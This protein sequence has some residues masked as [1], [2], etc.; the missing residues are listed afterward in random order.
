MESAGGTGLWGD[1]GLRSPSPSSSDEPALD[2]SMQLLEGGD[3]SAGPKDHPRPPPTPA[4]SLAHWPEIK[5]APGGME[6]A[7]PWAAL[8]GS[9]GRLAGAV[10]PDRWLLPQGALLLGLCAPGNAP[11]L[12][13]EAPP[14]PPDPTPSGDGSCLGA[15]SEEGPA[16][17]CPSPGLLSCPPSP[18][19]ASR[20]N[21]RPAGA[22]RLGSLQDGQQG[23]WGG[24]SALPGDAPSG[25]GGV[26]RVCCLPCAQGGRAPPH[27]PGLERPLHSPLPAAAHV[28]A[29]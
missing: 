29:Q 23:W 19:P 14:P 12:G 18:G 28:R 17:S 21:T 25:V 8:P 27:S 6:A 1:G 4:R 2:T 3:W 15:Q 22:T 16:P 24:P 9:P 13:Q 10:E 5:A 26:A 11:P 7:E 20:S